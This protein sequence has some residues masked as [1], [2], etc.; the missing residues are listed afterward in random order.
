M[1]DR[2]VTKQARSAARGG[3]MKT[4]GQPIPW[5]P[6]ITI[7][8]AA[9]G[10]IVTLLALQGGTNSR[11]DAV[12]VR[13]DAVNVRL[14]DLL[15]DVRVTVEDSIAEHAGP[16]V[17]QAVA[18]FFSGAMSIPPAAAGGRGEP[19]AYPPGTLSGETIDAI[20]DAVLA[21]IGE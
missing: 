14:D 11:I 20:A 5:T 9:A 4:P 21:R 7:A 1:L 13:I 6:I 3:E 10:L 8:I 19:D 16:A 2:F 18:D 17:T 15:S 12:N